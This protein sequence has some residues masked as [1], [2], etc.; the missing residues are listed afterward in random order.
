[1]NH[2]PL[3]ARAIG[4]SDTLKRTATA[5]SSHGKSGISNGKYWQGEQEFYTF[6]RSHIFAT[7]FTGVC[8]RRNLSTS[9]N[10]NM[11]TNQNALAER[12]NRSPFFPHVTKRHIWILMEDPSKQR[13]NHESTEGLGYFSGYVSKKKKNTCPS[14]WVPPVGFFSTTKNRPPTTGSRLRLARPSLQDQRAGQTW[15]RAPS[16]SLPRLE[17]PADFGSSRAE[18]SG[19]PVLLFGLGKKYGPVLPLFGL[20]KNTACGLSKGTHCCRLR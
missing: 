9:P 11:E 6:D 1:M 2:D 13:K 3:W 4:T 18:T 14:G 19:T 12:Q 17:P 16:G 7:W 10:S 5:P 8:A 15:R 20:G